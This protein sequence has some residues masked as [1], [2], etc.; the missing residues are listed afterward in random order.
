[1]L[2]GFVQRFLLTRPPRR[3]RLR[4][5]RRRQQRRLDRQQ[6]GR[7]GDDPG[8]SKFT[9]EDDARAGA[10]QRA[11]AAPAGRA[12]P[13]CW[14]WR[15]FVGAP[16][17]AAFEK[18]PRFTPYFRI[19]ALI[20]LLYAVYAV[21]V[22]SANGLRRFRTQASFDV[23]FSTPKTDPAARAR[24]ASGSVTG[25]FVGFAAAAAF[26]LVVA[27]RVMRL[28]AGGEPFPMRRHR[29]LHGRGRRLHGAAQPRAQLRPAAAAPVRAGA[30]PASTR[31]PPRPSPATTRRCARSRCCRTR[32]CW[33]SRS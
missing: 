2:S 20:P 9:A 11:G 30:R 25:A 33:W 27:S 5:L 19:A 16:A 4:R 12:G 21:F 14:R 18:A 23:G 1:M 29:R 8:V 24:R 31:P 28:P 15:C 26:I 7:A 32:R 10:V 6:H 13:A 3:R 22:G 17:L